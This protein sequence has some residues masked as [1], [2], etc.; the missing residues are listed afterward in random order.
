MF[1]T[2]IAHLM[3]SARLLLQ[4]VENPE[5]LAL[6]ECFI[7]SAKSPLHKVLMQHLLPATLKTFKQAAQEHCQGLEGTVSYDGWMGGNH[8]H[9]IAFMIHCIGQNHV[10]WVHDASGA[11]KTAVNLFHKMEEVIN[12]LE[13]NWNI[14][15]IALTS[16]AGGEVLKV[17]KMAQRKYPHLVAPDCYGHQNNLIVGDFFRSNTE[18]L[19]YTNKATELIGWL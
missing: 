1:E 4:W 14:I 6:C 7:P 3:A 17:C 9:Y 5:W 15:I 13:E 18:F 16:D 19:Q 11:C 8:H 10:I 2:A 12:D